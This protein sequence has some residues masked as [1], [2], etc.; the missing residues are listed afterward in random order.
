LSDADRAKLADLLWSKTTD[1]LLIVEPGTPAG[2][3]RIL[4]AR[5]QLF[6]QGAQVIAPCPHGRGCPL[7]PPDWCHFTQRLPR[8]RAHQQLKA[9]ELPYEDE[10]FIYVAL[11]RTPVAPRPARV[12][13]QPVITKISVTAKLCSD[14]GVV[15][16]TAPRRDKTA[17]ARFKKLDWGDIVP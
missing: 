1:T 9:A 4:Q 3:E 2:T 13:A 14:Q 16:T 10:K 5:E 12:L 17:Y 11:A 8:S 7:T 6:A 15:L